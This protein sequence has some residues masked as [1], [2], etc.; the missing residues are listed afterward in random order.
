[1]NM[2]SLKVGWALMSGG[3]V[4]RNTQDL[5]DGGRYGCPLPRAKVGMDCPL[6]R[7]NV[8]RVDAPGSA[9]GRDSFGLP[10]G[11]GTTFTMSPRGFPTV[12]PTGTSVM[13]A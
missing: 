2:L 4:I 3:V 6:P 8:P 1:M 5:K 9:R 11:P 7:A 13:I 12:P 10:V